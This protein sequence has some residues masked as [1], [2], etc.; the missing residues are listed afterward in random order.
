MSVIQG[1]V[2]A[3]SSVATAPAAQVIR[4]A[5]VHMRA[6]PIAPLPPP[7]PMAAAVSVRLVQNA[8]TVVTISST[9]DSTM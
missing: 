7:R 5:T 4:I 3:S 2:V 8:I 6:Q 9:G 1:A